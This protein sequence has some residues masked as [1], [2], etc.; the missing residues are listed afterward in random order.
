MKSGNL[1]FLEPSRPLQACNG[2]A[3]PF[4]QQRLSSYNRDGVCLLYGTNWI[5]KYNSDFYV[6][7]Y[8]ICGVRCCNG[9]GFPLN[10]SVLPG[11]Y[12]SIPILNFRRQN[13]LL[14]FSAHP[15][16][17]MWIIQEQKKV[18]LWNKQHFDE[19]NSILK[20]KK[21]SVC[22]MFKIFSTYICWINI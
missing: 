1:N 13:F 22:S 9:I 20:R 4:T 21:R 17:K 14:N 3:L 10:T 16:F 11:L 12:H 18:A 2:T 8:E 5:F 19:I 7:P 15:V 6:S